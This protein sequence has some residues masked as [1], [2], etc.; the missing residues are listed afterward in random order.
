MNPKSPVLALFLAVAALSAVAARAQTWPTRDQVLAKMHQANAYFMGKWPDPSKDIVTDKTRPSNLWTRGVYYEGLMALYRVD[1]DARYYQ[2]AVQWGT[3]HNWG[4]AY[5]NANDRVA[6]DQCC[7]QT[8]LELYAYDPQPVRIRDIKTSLD[9]MV[10]STKS[11]DWWWCDALHMGMP[12]FA[13]MGALTND[14]RY[15]QKMY[16]LFSNARSLQ[17]G[18]GLY[19]EQEHLWWRDATFIPPYKEPNGQNCYWGRGNGWVFAALARVLDVMPTQAPHRDEYLQM[20]RDMAAALK[21]LQRPDGFWNP[22]LL[23]TSDYGGRELSGTA[24]IAFGLAWGVNHGVLAADDY[25][26]TVLQAWNAM[27]QCAIRPDGSLAYV[28]STGKQPSDGQPITYDSVPN[29][30]DY[31]LGGVLLTGA[32]MI[33]MVSRIDVENVGIAKTASFVQTDAT[34]VTPSGAAPYGFE[35][36]VRGGGLSPTTVPAPWRV[37]L[38]DGVTVQPLAYDATLWQFHYTDALAS[39]TDLNARYPNGVYALAF[40]NQTIPNLQVGAGSGAT[41]DVFPNTPQAAVSAGT[42]SGGKLTLPV[43]Q[44]LTIATNTFSSNFGL[45]LSRVSIAINGA[46]YL[47]SAESRAYSTLALT[48]PAFSLVAGNTYTVTLTFERATSQWNDVGLGTLGP[49]ATVN[50]TFSEVT[51]FQIQTLPETAAYSQKIANV[52]AQGPVDAANVL[53]AGFVVNGTF[54]KTLLVRAVGPGL[55]KYGVANALPNPVLRL[56]N[57]NAT[58]LWQNDDWQSASQASALDSTGAATQQAAY[59]NVQAPD[60]AALTT[61]DFALAAKSRDAALVVCLAPGAYTAVV[62]SANGT[63]SGTVM[64][65]VYE[66]DGQLIQP[67]F[68]SLSARGQVAGGVPMTAGFVVRGGTKRLLVRAVGPALGNFGVSRTSL[69]TDP[70]LTIFD[71]AGR[72]VGANND[73][74]TAANQTAQL[75][76]RQS[77]GAFALPK[78]SKDAE[79]VVVLDPG[80]YTVQVN[81]ADGGSG[82]VLVEIYEDNTGL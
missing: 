62:G 46:R 54:A 55:Q 35:A 32:E 72:N 36:F 51:T 39:A 64:V 61:G 68:A 9:G 12:V 59:T 25:R 26:P 18:T 16:D 14:D 49:G 74:G 66:L 38:P 80:A 52:S 31:C 3:S 30:E 17:G 28:Q 10:N 1:P 40:A 33:D 67:R 63:D 15:Y 50:A 41:G 20:F 7:T 73:W 11:D 60:A 57:V 24:F 8:Y 76:L 6:D 81:G 4:L 29:F 70:Q 34:T 42:W 79:T 69:L 75:A 58:R 48:I 27:A 44:T 77:V 23:D 21:P 47:D 71:S 56:Y 53:I 65:E 43:S 78:N 82:I 2:Y 5:G 37:T 45:G 22:G 13:K 19:N